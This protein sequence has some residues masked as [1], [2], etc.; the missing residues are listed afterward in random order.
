MKDGLAKILPHTL[1]IV[2]DSGPLGVRD[3]SSA[4]KPVES[5]GE[6]DARIAR[7]I[8]DDVKFSLWCCV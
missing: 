7:V 5:Y 4:T 3:G 2:E 8:V 1:N 6:L